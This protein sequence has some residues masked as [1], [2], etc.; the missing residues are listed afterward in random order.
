MFC[1]CVNIFILLPQFLTKKHKKMSKKKSHTGKRMIELFGAVC[2]LFF[3]TSCKTT[4]FYQF[5]KVNSISEFSKNSNSMVFEDNNCKVMYDFWG[6]GGDVGFMIYN[7]TDDNIY[8]DMKECFFIDNSIAY[9][10][11]QNR[12]FTNTRTSS[13][14]ISN[15]NSAVYNYTGMNAM[16]LNAS[17]SISG[18]NYQGF[19]SIGAGVASASAVSSG[20]AVTQSKGVIA[21]SGTSTSYK[22]MKIICIPAKTAK[23][24][25]GYVITDALYRD[26]DLLRYPSKGQI[27]TLK[28]SN[29]KSPFVFSNRITYTVGKSENPFTFENKFYVSEITNYPKDAVKTTIDE[30]YC[31][32]KGDAKL[33]VFKNYSPDSFYIPYYKEKSK[34]K[35]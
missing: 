11:F 22:E 20:I 3:I 29:N 12:T 35:H 25:S 18:T 5:Y 15:S 27:R 13:V 9:D 1:K 23:V 17:K 14:S 31:G 30:V 16:G 33:E 32:E 10:Y 6:E 2:V 28:F 7:K 8:I 24:I 26:C 21:S 19:K 4:D 34:F